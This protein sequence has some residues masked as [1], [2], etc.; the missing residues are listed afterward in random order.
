[1]KSTIR[2]KIVEKKDFIVNWD[3]LPNEANFVVIEYNGDTKHND[4]L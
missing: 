2:L 3:E 4:K 1:M